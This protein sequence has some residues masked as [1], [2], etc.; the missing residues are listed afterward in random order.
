MPPPRVICFDIGGVIV[1]I[2]RSWAEGCS[3]AGLDLRRP[4]VHEAT[5][6]ARNRLVERYQ[7]GRM[8][9]RDYF[10]Q[11]SELHERAYSPREVEAVH[12]AWL[13]EQFPGVQTIVD[14]INAAGILTAA[15]SN[16]NQAHW[17]RMGEFPA[18]TAI[19]QHFVSHRLGLHKPDARIFHAARRQLGVAP[20]AILYFDDLAE[21]VDAA[22]HCGWDSVQIDPLAGPASQI[23]AAVRSRSVTLGD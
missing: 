3:A 2:C 12:H 14:S 8:E 23:A 18:V 9:T 1:R 11:F 7:T 4:D 10:H 17:S 13:I 5:A 21:N 20:S 22:R 19:R 15:L 6:A 16:T